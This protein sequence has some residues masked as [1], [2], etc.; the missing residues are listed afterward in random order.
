MVSGYVETYIDKCAL[1]GQLLG[2]TAIVYMCCVIVLLYTLSLCLRCSL[3]D[4]LAEERQE[5]PD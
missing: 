3:R 1:T 2:S 5:F 4:R